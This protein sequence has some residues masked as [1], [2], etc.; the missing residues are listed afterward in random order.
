VEAKEPD[1]AKQDPYGA[2]SIRGDCSLIEENKIEK[3][4]DLI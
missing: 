4:S 2:L 1:L 3:K